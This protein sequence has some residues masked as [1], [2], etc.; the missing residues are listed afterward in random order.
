MLRVLRLYIIP[1]AVALLL[2]LAIRCL[3]V[4]QFVLTEERADGQLLRGDRILVL[5]TA[6][7]LRFPGER[8]FG[9]RRIGRP[10]AAAGDLIAFY[11]PASAAQPESS[12]PVAFGTVAAVPGDTLWLDPVRQLVLPGRTSVDALPFVVPRKGGKARICPELSPLFAE[13]LRQTGCRVQRDRQ[14][15]LLVGGTPL[16][17]VAFDHD[18]YWIETV[19]EH[20]V[21]LSETAVLGK[22]V[23][24][25]Y[26]LDPDKPFYAALRM[27]RFF[28]RF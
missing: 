1:C 17:E 6:Y 19:P 13:I 22:P 5:R 20:F 14:G 21:L 27:G 10:D 15:R 24:V 4:A 11:S 8:L 16:Q 23:L 26:S 2:L 7:G 18:F 12:R 25:S 28:V 3:L 9:Y